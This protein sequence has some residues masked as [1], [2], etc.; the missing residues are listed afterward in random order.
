VL[1]NEALEFGYELVVATQ[2]QVRVNSILET[3][4]ARLF[5]VRDLRLCE[6]LVCEVGQPRSSPQRESV[7]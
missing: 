3:R 4:E 2:A 7:A 5:Q 6:R 1:T